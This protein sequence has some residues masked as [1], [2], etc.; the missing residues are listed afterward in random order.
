MLDKIREGAT[1][2]A[3]KVI[4]GLVILSFVFAGVGSYINSGVD[5]AIAEV[6]GEEISASTFEQAYQSERSR[7]EAQLGDAFSQLAANSEYLDSFR[8]NVLN[9]LINDKLLEQKS[10]NLGIRVSDSELRETILTMNEFSVGGQFN[11]DR[12]QALLMQAG[13]TPV[14][15]RTYL[16]NQL[17]RQQLS[18]AVLNSEFSLES[19][20][21]QFLTMQN[22]TRD[23]RYLEVETDSFKED[24]SISE[25]E[26]SDYY[27]ANINQFDTEEKV[28]VQYVEIK[29]DDFIANATVEDEQIELYY[30]ENQSTYRSEE[31]RRAS[32]ILVEFDDD[33]DAAK[34]KAE[35]LYESLVNGGD[36]AE[37][38]KTSSDDTFSG[39]NGG[40]LDWFGKGVMDPDFEEAAFALSNRGDLSDVVKSEFGFHVIKLTDI[41]E[42]SIKPLEEVRED[43]IEVLKKDAAVEEY[44]D[45]QQNMSEVAF[46]SLDSL[47]DVA[48]IA[49]VEIKETALFTR[50]LPPPPFDN[51]VLLNQAFSETLIEEGVNSEVIEID[52]EHFVFLRVLEHETER[53]KPMSEVKSEIENKLYDEKAL[54]NALQWGESLI[55]ELGADVD[56]SEKLSEKALQWNDKTNVGRYSGDIAGK[57]NTELFKLSKVNEARAV[58]LSSKKVGIIQLLAV[59]VPEQSDPAEVDSTQQRLSQSNGQNTFSVLLEAVNDEASIITTL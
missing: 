56:I 48:A 6:N 15:F 54:V 41:K 8:E 25:D 40:D 20:A 32:H 9:R 13:F 39:E 31:Q 12:Y 33:E 14:E 29:V 38:A 7:M 27:Q 52:D 24:I 35:A 55:A 30:E 47:D 1:G 46:E 4:L 18:G 42:E 34:L 3:A 11:N 49:D 2:I 21:S 50:L 22:E 59:N 10:Q 19:E 16:R 58:E 51:N 43:I 44:L 36:F 53:T 45:V 28:S 23:A 5:N 17:T 57:L 37:L 26:I